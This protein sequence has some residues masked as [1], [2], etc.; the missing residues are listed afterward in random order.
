[1]R[2]HRLE[3]WLT[4]LETLHAKSI[5]M[6][7]ERV[8]LVARRLG[9]LTQTVPV[10]MVSGTN[11]KGSTT[12]LLEALLRAHGKQ[13]GCYTSPHILR[14][15]ERIRSHGV[16]VADDALL[17]ALAAVDAAR[18]DTSLTYFEFT[19]LAA[20]VL[21][22]QANLDVWVLEIGLGGRLD[23]VNIVDADVAVLTS[24]GLDHQE[25]L[26]DTRES[27]GREK[28]G[29]FRAGRPA[30]V[31]DC[32]PP[33]SVLA[34]IDTLGADGVLAG[35]DYQYRTGAGGHWSWQGRDRH[36]R[37]LSF[38]ALPLP[39]LA[40]ANAATALQAF[41]LLPVVVDRDAVCQA[42][43]SVQ[44]PG[45][46]QRI[47]VPGRAIVVDVGHNADALRFLT[48]ELPRHGLGMR[49]HVVLGML[50][51]KDIEAA[52]RVL[53]PLASSWHIAP[54]PSPRTAS[55]ERLAQALA[56]AGV[57]S[58][59]IGLHADV[60][61]ALAAARGQPD[62]LPVL[63][64]GSF[65]MAGGALAALGWQSLKQVFAQQSS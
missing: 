3:D 28:A 43:T 64:V 27:I 35:R 34:M 57:G 4:W 59:Q 21:F 46:N 17:R 31:G 11:G 20:L 40:L 24:V 55:V 32:T 36:R 38:A 18:G 13:V 2:F 29:I 61:G 45:R 53:E 5:D 8:R 48:G 58:S 62:A 50:G 6:G 12:A 19:T 44:L 23:A 51:D 63:V 39:S 26:G 25:W 47:D 33:A 1:M 14:F 42:L 54:L 37:A 30:V 49:F 41:V 15:N 56:A 9:V 22:G 16:E 60:A 7:L 52:V 10:V 65:H